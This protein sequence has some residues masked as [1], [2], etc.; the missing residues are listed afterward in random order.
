METT[1]KG[2]YTNHNIKQLYE[3]GEPVSGKRKTWGKSPEEFKSIEQQVLV[4]AIVDLWVAGKLLPTDTE[5]KQAR[6]WLTARL[7]GNDLRFST[8]TK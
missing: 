2:E 7:Q 6:I 5:V 1:T 8:I 3:G 4:K